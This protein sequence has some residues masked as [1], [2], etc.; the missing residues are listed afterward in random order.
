VIQKHRPIAYF[1]LGWRIQRLI[2]G[3]ID[4]MKKQLILPEVL[5]AHGLKKEWIDDPEKHRQVI[6][7]HLESGIGYESVLAKDL[8]DDEWNLARRTG[9]NLTSLSQKRIGCL[10]R[11]AA[12]LTELQVRLY[13]PGI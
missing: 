12:N 6:Q 4:N 2:P 3:F 10:I 13:C 1:S 9:T 7:Q 11:H 5:F 8:T